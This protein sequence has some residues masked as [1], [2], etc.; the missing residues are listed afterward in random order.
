M[1]MLPMASLC[2]NQISPINFC[3]KSL[4]QLA[5]YIQK[6]SQGLPSLSTFNK[7]LSNP[8]PKLFEIDKK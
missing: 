6:R 4:T 5:K 3:F 1:H 8:F 7:T 2:P